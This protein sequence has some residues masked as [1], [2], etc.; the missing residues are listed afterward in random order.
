[1]VPHGM[2]MSERKKDCLAAIARVAKD[3]RQGI[4]C[5]VTRL[6]PIQGLITD[7]WSCRDYYLFLLESSS[8]LFDQ[9]LSMSSRRLVEGREKRRIYSEAMRL[10][11]TLYNTRE[12]IQEAAG[13]ELTDLYE[14]IQS[15]SPG[16]KR[17][18]VHA[19][20]RRK[21][22]DADLILIEEI[23]RYS[24]NQ[25]FDRVWAY[26]LTRYYVSSYEGLRFLLDQRSA[27]RI[28]GIVDF[29][30]NPI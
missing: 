29:L 28:M 22:P 20:W 10:L 11:H 4:P 8:I 15:L 24:L 25:W 7:E 6:L 14:G 3:L 17:I 9:G 30:G 5:Q 16:G 13:R 23:L 12:G 27:D 21:L 2:S 19:S 1:M 26:R 18:S